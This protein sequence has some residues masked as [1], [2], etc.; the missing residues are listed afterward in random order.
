MFKKLLFVFLF[1]VQIT[2]YSQTPGVIIGEMNN[3]AFVIN[4]NQPSLVKA[5]E[6]TFK[7]G[8]KVTE[9][10]ITQLGNEYY[11]LATCIYQGRKRIAAIDID[12]VGINFVLNED[13]QFKMCSAVACETCRF[14][15]ENNKIVACKCEE[16]GTISNHCHYKASVGNGYF[17][18]FQRAQRMSK[19]EHN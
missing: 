3:S 4:N 1:L 18:N 11:L 5:F 12:L 15:F 13:A 10:A 16:T 9:M 14:F 19:D 6:W 17:A 2:A 8:T 7:D